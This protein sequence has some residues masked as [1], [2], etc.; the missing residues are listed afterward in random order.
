MRTKIILIRHGQS[1]GNEKHVLLGHTD[2]DLSELGYRQAYATAEALKDEKIDVVYS[3]P[4]LRAYNTAVPNAAL[5]KAEVL[6]DDGLKEIYLGDWENKSVSEIKEKWGES[7]YDT[8]WIENFGTFTMPSGESTW[9][10]G[11]RFRCA[12]ERIAKENGGKT[13]LIAAHAAVIRSFFGNISGLTR[14][15]ISRELPFPSNASYSVV[16]F[17]GENFTAAEYSADSH[18][19][20]VGITKFEKT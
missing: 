17:D 4:L 5:R 12:V 3:S 19:N 1:L 13:V 11:E 9:G 16:Y 18:L 14:E 10:A 15:T 20:G 8:D 6:T 7:V 2:L